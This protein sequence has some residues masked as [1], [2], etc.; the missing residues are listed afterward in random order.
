MK[1]LELNKLYED[2]DENTIDYFRSKLNSNAKINID[3]ENYLNDIEWIEMMELTIPYIDNI[4]RSPNRFIVNEEEIVKIELARKITVDSIKHLSKHTNLIQEVDKKN[5]NVRPSKILNIHKEESVDTYE[6]R[7]IYTLI[8]N[9]KMFSDRKRKIVEENLKKDM[10][11]EK[12]ITYVGTARV[13][14]ED[15][16]IN[17]SL[18]TALNMSDE[19]KQ[20][21]KREILSRIDAIDKKI[22]D[23][24][25]TD[26]YKQ[27]D[28]LHIRL[29][30][31]PIKKTN[32]VLK[33]VNFQYAVKLWDYIQDHLDN[34]NEP[35]EEHK[36]YIDTG[37]VK[38][39]ADE[40][41][42]ANYLALNS[43][44]NKKDN[45]DTQEMTKEELVEYLL[46]RLI[47]MNVNLTVEQIKELIGDKFEKIK[48][49]KAA[50]LQEIQSIF[51][52]YIDEYM[53]QL[54]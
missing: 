45:N 9:M 8:Q 40:T 19:E 4:L 47:S 20:S 39:V 15:V 24:T 3:Y 53:Q 28:K 50:T 30:R 10:K 48:Y 7:L 32:L 17:L 25:F 14:N 33:N 52:K 2:T 11:D 5:D 36:E 51:K 13:H 6:N 49:R 43:L 35:T 54:I 12:K 37:E 44:N 26:V 21:K 27:I 18:S 42:L 41:F 46:D 31:P 34:K 38:Q 29:I 16:A 1:E 23:L 22:N